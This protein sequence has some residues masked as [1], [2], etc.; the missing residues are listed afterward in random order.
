M[1]RSTAIVATLPLLFALYVFLSG[2]LGGLIC[3]CSTHE[4]FGNSLYFASLEAYGWH[5]AFFSPLLRLAGNA[6]LGEAL[7]SYWTFCGWGVA[8]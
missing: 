7:L 6:G 5:F 2:P 4:I 8:A 1:K 3:Y